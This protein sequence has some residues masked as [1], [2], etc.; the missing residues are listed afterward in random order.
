MA[1]DKTDI[2]LIVSL[3]HVYDGSII[4]SFLKNFNNKASIEVEVYDLRVAAEKD[5]IHNA[6]QFLKC[7]LTQRWCG[8]VYISYNF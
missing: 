7:M 2:V 1:S 5:N 3:S 6:V 4:D 8:R